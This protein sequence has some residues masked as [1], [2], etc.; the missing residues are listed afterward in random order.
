M[1]VSAGAGTNRMWP[2]AP[3]WSPTPPAVDGRLMV[4]WNIS[5]Y[6]IPC[7][8]S[9]FHQFL[10]CNQQLIDSKCPFH[11]VAVVNK[12]QITLTNVSFPIQSSTSLLRPYGLLTFNPD[13]LVPWQN[14]PV[15]VLKLL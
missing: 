6:K 2:N 15:N 4:V 8:R 7:C 10:P 12:Q 13:F 3:V 11:Q 5:L 14:A 9:G 1:P